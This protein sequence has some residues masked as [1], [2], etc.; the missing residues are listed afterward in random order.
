[1]RAVEHVAD[2]VARAELVECP[3]LNHREIAAGLAIGRPPVGPAGQRHVGRIAREIEA[4]DRAAH[5]LFFPV[6]VEIGQQRGARSA[7]GGM[8]I[9]VDP[10]GGHARFPKSLLAAGYAAFP[11]CSRW[12]QSARVAG[13]AA[14]LC[15]RGERGGYAV[16]S[17][18]SRIET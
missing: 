12:P 14:R 3:T 15:R 1:L 13:E 17:P 10:R 8:D 16:I 11:M 2:R 5:H 7:H 18:K 6:I 9:A 4:I